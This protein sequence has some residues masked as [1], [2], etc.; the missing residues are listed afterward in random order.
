MVAVE[1]TEQRKAPCY[2][3]LVKNEFCPNNLLDTL[4]PTGDLGG[5][6]SQNMS[7]AWLT[8]D[9]GD[10]MD[11]GTPWKETSE[12]E[13]ASDEERVT[14]ISDYE[15][16]LD[17]EELNVLFRRTSARMGRRQYSEHVS[18]AWDGSLR[19]PAVSSIAA[20]ARRAVEFVDRVVL[21][22][23]SFLGAMWMVR[24]YFLHIER[25]ARLVESHDV[26]SIG[27]QAE[28]KVIKRTTM[29][30]FEAEE[31]DIMEAEDLRSI[32]IQEP[33]M[34]W[35]STVEEFRAC[36]VSGIVPPWKRPRVA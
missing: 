20:I 34:R 3:L 2:Q 35:P 17:L 11:D 15:D 30:A 26:T 33:P 13:V 8:E 24:W 27:T 18:D 32:T 14:V 9:G 4:C 23:S 16:L 21:K 36:G 6:A 22:R 31:R 7:E 28:A 5:M 25:R 10:I 19:Y 1:A 29:E 12:S